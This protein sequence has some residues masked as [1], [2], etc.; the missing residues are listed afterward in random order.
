[1]DV[2]VFLCESMYQHTDWFNELVM[3]FVFLKFFAFLS[4]L[5]DNRQCSG[6]E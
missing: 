6:W 1:M 3:R 2:D 5:D 4:I